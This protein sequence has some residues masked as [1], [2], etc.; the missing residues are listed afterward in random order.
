M[1]E[2][3]Q[4]LQEVGNTLRNTQMGGTSRRHN[5]QAALVIGNS[6]TSHYWLNLLPLARNSC[7]RYY[8]TE[9]DLEELADRLHVYPQVVPSFLVFHHGYIV[10]WFPAPLPPPGCAQDP[11]SLIATVQDRLAQYH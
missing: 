4:I 1:H 5:V 8:I 6:L 7:L 10:D 3:V 9:D 2:E 11:L